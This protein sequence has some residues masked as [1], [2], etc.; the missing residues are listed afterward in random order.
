MRCLLLLFDSSHRQDNILLPRLYLTGAFY[1]ILM[2]TGSNVVPIATFL[3]DTHMLQAYSND[4]ARAA[5][6][7]PPLTPLPGPQ[8]AQHLGLDAAG[9]HGLLPAE[10]PCVARRS[11]TL[12]HANAA[13][14]K[15]ASIF[16][17]DFDTPE[18]IWGPE[19]R[20]AE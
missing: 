10:L 20:S 6:P 2:Y 9:R 19:M 18:V 16:L 3:K 12:H 11:V 8:V 15:F 14:E 17:G 1:F 5:L 7:V 13:P 4:P